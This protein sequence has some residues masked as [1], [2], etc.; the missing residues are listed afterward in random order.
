[1]KNRLTKLISVF[2][3]F[4]MVFQIAEPALASLVE[5]EPDASS[6]AAVWKPYT[7]ELVLKDSEGNETVVD[8]SW[9]EVYPFGAFAFGMTGGS[10][11]EGEDTV[12][13]LYRAGGTHGRAT[14]YIEY[15]PV[16]VSNEDGS[17]YLGYGL[18]GRDIVIE[19]EDPLP[20]AEY[21]AVGKYDDPEPGDAFVLVDTDDEGYVLTLSEEAEEYHWQVLNDGVWT[22]II[23]SDAIELKTDA[24]YLVEYDFRCIYTKDDARF[25][26]ASLK[27]VAYEKP[28]QAEPADP[29][30]DIELNPEKTFSVLPIDDE[31][32]PYSGWRFA[33]TFADGEWKKEIRLHA[34]TDDEAEALE[35]GAT[36]RIADTEG[37]EIYPG[38]ETYMFTVEDINESTPSEV[39][40]TVQEAYAD[41]ADGKVVLTVRREGG[42]ER[43]VSVEY[44]TRDGAAAAGRDYAA[45]EGVLMFYGNVTEQTIEI[46][47]IDD[48]TADDE[49]RD[50]AVTIGELKGDDKCVM[51]TDSAA[52]WLTNSGTG[53]AVNVASVFYDPEAIDMTASV[54]ESPTSA[55]PAGQAV[56]GDQVVLEV[57]EPVEMTLL[58][59]DD[60]EM[61]TQVHDY[62]N[63]AY[64]NYGTIDFTIAVAQLGDKAWENTEDL[65][66]AS[67]WKLLNN[68][69]EGG[70]ALYAKGNTI[71]GGYGYVRDPDGTYYADSAFGN[72]YVVKNGLAVAGTGSGDA[73]LKEEYEKTLGQKYSGYAASYNMIY[74]HSRSTYVAKNAK[75]YG[76]W[77]APKLMIGTLK[78]IDNTTLTFN[79][80]DILNKP[81]EPKG[82][83][84]VGFINAQYAKNWQVEGLGS[85]GTWSLNPHHNY[86][87]SW[88]TTGPIGVKIDVSFTSTNISGKKKE[89]CHKTLINLSSLE[90]T[91]RYFRED[92][93]S[94][95]IATPND[96][97]TGVMAGAVEISDYKAYLPTVSLESG[98]VRKNGDTLINSAFVGSSVIVT[99][100]AVPGLSVQD[101]L[102]L[103]TD[104]KPT[105]NTKWQVFGSFNVSKYGTDGK[106]IVLMDPSGKNPLKENEI[107]SY[108]FRFR[109]V[110]TRSNTITVDLSNSLPRDENGNQRDDAEA[111]A[112][113]F[114]NYTPIE[115]GPNKGKAQEDHCFA[116]TADGEDV[117][118][119][120]GYSEYD[121]DLM[122]YKSTIT[123]DSYLLYTPKYGWT[124]L[125]LTMTKVYPA[126]PKF[127]LPVDSNIQWI[128]FGLDK[129]DLLLFNGRGYSGDAK[130]WLTEEDLAGN[131]KVLYYH[132]NYQGYINPMTTAVSWKAIYLDGDGDGAITGD[133]VNGLFVLT[134]PDDQFVQYLS[135]GDS[136][137][138]LE[139]EPIK[140]ENGD[141]A[142]YYI[143]LCYTMTP[144]C[145]EPVKGEENNCAQVL[146]AFTTAVDKGAASYAEQTPEQ[147]KYTYIESGKLS[148]NGE[149][150]SDNHPMFRAEANKKTLLAIPLG[151]DKSPAHLNADNSGYEW[152]PNWFENYLVPFEHPDL[153]TI[154]NSL[155]GPTAVADGKPK[156]KAT[157]KGS[158]IEYEYSSDA[159]RQ[160]NGYLAS[161]NGTTTFLLVSAIQKTTTSEYVTARDTAGSGTPLAPPVSDSNTFGYV[162]TVPDAAYLKVTRDSEA[163][164]FEMSSTGS[165]TNKG[166]FPELAQSFFTAFGSNE[167]GVTNWVTIIAE[168]N[169]VGFCISIPLISGETDPNNNDKWGWKDFF[170]G[171]NGDYL[172][173]LGKLGDRANHLGDE[174]LQKTWA[175]KNGTSTPTATPPASPGTPQPPAQGTPTR[176]QSNTTPP[177]PQ[178]RPSTSGRSSSVPTPSSALT[179]QDASSSSSNTSSNTS[180][181]A[182]PASTSKRVSSKKFSV[183]LS[184]Q[185]CFIWEYDPLNNG[186]HFVNW[187]IGIAGELEF[188]MEARFT[189]CPP[190]YI[191][192]D[193]KLSVEIMTGVKVAQTETFGTDLLTATTTSGTGSTTSY[194]EKVEPVT[195]SYSAGAA[196]RADFRMTTKAFDITF[197][198][199]L[200]V[201]VLAKDGDS[202]TA[203]KADEMGYVSGTISSSGKEPVRVVITNTYK[204]LES[205]QRDMNLKEPVMIRLWAM[206]TDKGETVDETTISSIKPITKLESE[207]RWAGLKL[208]PQIGIEVGA[209]VGVELL[210]AEIFLHV[211]IGG[212]FMMF[213]KND[214]YYDGVP[215]ASEYLPPYTESFEFVAGIAVRVVLA[216]LSYE[217]DLISYKISYEHVPNAKGIWKHGIYYVN[218]MV[219]PDEWY[220]TEDTDDPDYGVTAR[221][222]KDMTDSQ[223][224]YGPEDN[225]V[226]EMNTQAYDF[227][228]PSIPFQVSGFASSADAVNLTENIPEGSSYKVIRAGGQNFLVY[229]LS[230]SGT[231]PE[232][233]T[234]LVMS[235]LTYD[236]SLNSYGLVNPDPAGRGEGEAKYIVLD[237]EID[238]T[239]DL[240]FDVW[241]E[242]TDD[243]GF[244][245]HAV[246]VSYAAPAVSTL[247]PPDGEPYTNEKNGTIN[248][249]NYKEFAA[250]EEARAWYDYY[251]ALSSANAEIEVRAKHAAE[252]T[253]VKTAS[254]AMDGTAFSE[255]VVISDNATT[256]YVFQ[257][258]SADDGK[259]IFYGSTFRQDNGD[260][261]DA[262]SAYQDSKSRNVKITNYLKALRRS[263]LDVMGIQSAMNL[264]VQNE[265]G[266]WS[267]FPAALPK[268]QTLSNV[269]FAEGTNNDWYVAYT[270]EQTTYRDGDM[271][272]AYHLYLRRAVVEN[273]QGSWGKPVLIRELRDYDQNTG[274]DGAYSRGLC[275]SEYDDPYFADLTFLTANVDRDMLTGGEPLSELEIQ[276]VKNQL[277]LIFEMNGTTYVIPEDML[278]LIT[279]GG[280]GGLI[281]PFFSPPLH[282]NA[283]GE[284]VPEGA[285]GKMKT[286]ICADEKGNLYA[287]YI[288]NVSGTTGNALYLSTYDPWTNTWS[289]GVMLAMH[290][291]NT[292]ETA[293]GNKWDDVT[294][295]AAYLYGLGTDDLTKLYGS[296]VVETLEK[297]AP[298]ERDRNL[299]DAKTFTFNALQT[300]VGEKGELLI[301]TGGSVKEMTVSTYNDGEETNYILMPKT[302]EDT[303]GI[304]TVSGNYAVSFGEGQ[305]ALSGAIYFGNK[306]FKAEKQIYV[307]IEAENTGTTSFRGSEDQPI[308]AILSVS[309]YELARWELGVNVA[310]GQ[311]MRFDG[312]TVPLPRNL[313]QGD[314]FVLTLIENSD[315]ANQFNRAPITCDLEL[316]TVESKPDLGV[317]EL[318]IE[319]K[320][321]SEDGMKTT[322]DVSF[323]ATNQGSADTKDVYVQFSYAVGTDEAGD[324]IYVPLN[325]S[326]NK[327]EVGP[328]TALSEL[329]T[330]QEDE[331]DLK[332]GILRLISKDHNNDI[333]A[334]LSAGYG[335]RVSGTITVSK[336]VFAAGESGHA[337]IQVEIFDG[338]DSMTVMN[339]GQVTVSSDEYYTADNAVNQ[340]VEAYT[341]FNAAHNIIIPLGTTTKLALSAVSSRGTKPVIAVEEIDDKNGLNIGIL[342]F[343]QS[344][345]DKGALSGILSITP[346]Q[347]GTG[348]IHVTDTAT[349]SVYSI[350]FEVVNATKGIDIF[351]DNASF[352]FYNYNKPTEVFDDKGVR[353]NQSWSF[354]GTTK[355]GTKFEDEVNQKTIDT[356][357]T[358]LRGNLSTGDQYAYFTFNS[359]ASSIDLYFSGTVEVTKFD[360]AFTE[361]VIVSNDYGGNSPTTIELNDNPENIPYTIKVRILSETATFD[362]LVETFTNE[363]PVPEYDGVS[364]V[365]IW[366]RSF[367]DT[368]SVPTGTGIPLKVY[369]LDNNGVGN[370]TIEKGKTQEQITDPDT[371]PAMTVIDGG[372]LV[373]CYDF[374]V[375]TENCAANQPYVLTATDISGNVV[376]ETL[377][378]DWFLANPTGDADTV[379]VP[380]YTPFFEQNGTA[381]GARTLGTAKGL[382][383]DFSEDASNRKKENNTHT[384]DYFSGEEFIPITAEADGT[385]SVDSNGLYVAYTSN[386][387][388]TWSAAVLCMDLLDNSLPQVRGSYDGE[389]GCLK[390]NAYK[391]AST[392]LPIN[393]VTINDCTVSTE[394]GISLSGSFPVAFNGTYTI[395]ATD[396][397]GRIGSIERNINDA[398][399]QVKPSAETLFIENPSGG[400]ATFV[401][402]LSA[403]ITGGP[404]DP[405]L[406]DP[407]SG[408]YKASYQTA[409]LKLDSADEVPNAENVEWTG[410]T[411]ATVDDPGSMETV[412]TEPGFYVIAAKTGEETAF[413][414]LITVAFSEETTDPIC[415][416]DGKI[417]YK[418]TVTA[419]REVFENTCEKILPML[420]HEW[421]DPT[422]FW[423]DDNS[424]VTASRTCAHDETHVEK[425][426]VDTAAVTKDPVC[427][428]GGTVTYTATFEN[429]AFETQ[430]KTVDSTV[431]LGHAWGKPTY[432]WS[433]DNGKVTATRIC[434]HDQTHVETETVDTVSET[435]EPDCENAGTIT[436]TA[437]FENTEFATQTK[438]VES[439]EA[440]GHDWG[441]PTYAWSDDKSTVT[442]KSVCLRDPSHVA[443]ETVS[444]KYE[445]VT[446]PQPEEEGLGRYTATFENDLFKEQTQD[447]VLPPTGYTYGEPEFAWTDDGHVTVTF[448][449]VENPKGNVT[450]TDEDASVTVTEETTEPACTETGKTVYT[451]TV[452]F[453]EETYTDTHET[454]LP[455]TGHDWGEP[456]F[457]WSDDKKSAVA[458]VTCG[459]D[460]HHVR[461]FNTVVRMDAPVILGV[462]AVIRTATVVIDG[463]TYHDTIW[464]TAPVWIPRLPIPEKETTTQEETPDPKKES[465][466]PFIDVKPEDTFYDDVKYVYDKGI[467]NGVSETEFDPLSDLS[468]GMIVTVLYRMEGRPEVPE[469]NVFTDVPADMW[470]ADGVTWA[471]SKG[472][473]NGYGDGTY[474]PANPVTREQ[475]AAILNR[476]ADFRGY[477]VRTEELDAADAESVSGWAA[478]NVKWAAANGILEAGADGTIRP[479]EPAS[480]AEIAGA[481][482]AFLENVAE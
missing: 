324:P 323:V 162:Y 158:V 268:G 189:P 155:A 17:I 218:D 382:G 349:N 440:L 134:D 283:D 427:T 210:K 335:K 279:S 466:L 94:V 303:N 39:G 435:V 244:I 252:N 408:T 197:A 263:T 206:Q 214:D 455:E 424:M 89:Q 28:E 375:I 389:N 173:G 1:M 42:S 432:K 309:G 9:N 308:T 62:G 390:W 47:L 12:I 67:K 136:I 272:T 35:E 281:Y 109:V 344:A 237:N 26:T 457:T 394:E 22:D 292:Y 65:A 470:Y 10:V 373:W 285:A 78:S 442:A 29:P 56:M 144:R 248:G 204:A 163:P 18:S 135:D 198:G 123:E 92:A 80:G 127:T 410:T 157:E 276:E 313:Q 398:A 339:G 371:T 327:L 434:V 401:T 295:E 352:T 356:V 421:S 476:Y 138:E 277:L 104:T 216:V 462:P 431:P 64:A 380:E 294:T 51:G 169:L 368:A 348:V 213:S 436:Y 181:N 367:P 84:A 456:V 195:L 225:A 108:Y 271:V 118:I 151:G 438:T 341:E 166:E 293:I 101:I 130:I 378:I 194:D 242:E 413:S 419:G 284:W 19:V 475:L 479:T 76:A 259:V 330:T 251:R 301:V 82:T 468:R 147:K 463:Q 337:Q 354:L 289:S 238:P 269:E 59:G 8:E 262:Y 286:S 228:D 287:V 425:E 54:A 200:Y 307:A 20:V 257:P 128:C 333:N 192:L 70:T 409:L 79:F 305:H 156:E 14:A 362:R 381:V 411:E 148:V 96:A 102:V 120:V 37:G 282:E 201:Q 250:E 177:S 331:S 451:V 386:A 353:A 336:D 90:M 159:L 275:T 304:K 235:K 11:K 467:M 415:E 360:P 43:P 364:P 404:Y 153:I 221:L 179:A 175:K 106:K 329:L 110:Y 183:Q 363:V 227:E 61:S 266:S 60:G 338:G 45:A 165:T 129:R 140:L 5:D 205:E 145:L 473:V 379:F 219:D 226:D 319:R 168:E 233:S 25:C 312:F 203:K 217:L 38:A 231:E 265:D 397:D 149:Y 340:R 239:G 405:T 437:A 193:V 98:G 180:N 202:Y 187:G 366:S 117:T 111:Y 75:C 186:Y 260:A 453:G 243:G 460:T 315:Y 343:K 459:N 167:I 347:T 253:V 72:N 7:E 32:D 280:E 258:A 105:E 355:W 57:P 443:E 288:G 185:S 358:P 278:T 385:F 300:A 477:A 211:S 154:K 184:V 322:F 418:V 241:A 454:V 270:T 4:L 392:A 15:M 21:Q 112:M 69:S 41:K 2:L 71:S 150:T 74:S 131:I 306:N 334:N 316:F 345:A 119:T 342:N 236:D 146:P 196:D 24:E 199:K 33:V 478:E 115:E 273:G 224:V 240:D 172:E 372:G 461:T 208:S 174:T 66:D 124:G 387:D 107:S 469:M 449:A 391:K 417:V 464:D 171:P 426:T 141:F 328:E 346:T 245:I 446:D 27:G 100:K 152:T 430:T 310:P 114:N 170:I 433:E 178:P 332:N 48:R 116:L 393:S 3:S 99:P 403:V 176:Q 351:R 132:E 416:K 400:S 6:D 247:L 482:R 49:A 325:I 191:Y 314:K 212:E 296:E 297:L 441:E 246:W 420:I 164:A 44:A 30:E 137:N 370:L 318:S 267:V 23:A 95:D 458:T 139:L 396:T 471:A 395:T 207:A 230:R 374:G 255:P 68:G 85:D 254:W 383:I 350:A 103:Y 160:I 261:Y 321:I 53:T 291:M 377:W 81:T 121:S 384:V 93:F 472:I 34:N 359:A 58:S 83:K 133:Y 444:T 223:T 428:E 290:D 320:S 422:Y 311:A 87:G 190:L 406:S 369:I 481:I 474:G 36:F 188:R 402:N 399:I 414:D 142:Q 249:D 122:D 97:N 448:P 365:F 264:A 445:I 77:T 317:H 182:S 302:D 361:S 452:I 429:P 447:V 274:T 16:A 125:D 326:E 88:Q 126:E 50:F 480:R 439:K 40:F 232:D 450:L 209:G 113:L 412:I 52:V 86:S 46:E 161:F 63:D 465:G 234:M 13:T 55:S 229:A 256:D 220:F 357:E 299:G 215:G 376:T 423:E 143:L 388:H 31:D 298:A 91:R 73:E 407:A 222:P